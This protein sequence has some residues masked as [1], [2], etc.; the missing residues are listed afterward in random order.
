MA[1]F[2]F[3]LDSVLRWR[4]AERDQRR[5]AVADAMRLEQLA[6]DRIIACD[7]E[8]Q[9]L[10]ENDG[11][12]GAID[13][14]RRVASEQYAAALRRDRQRL[15]VE[16]SER[17]AEVDSSRAALVEADREVRMLERLRERKLEAFE[18]AERRRQQSGMEELALRKHLAEQDA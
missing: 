12:T 6:Q 18:A 14:A 3:A 1:K 5:Q 2:T 10:R 4:T 17:T 8:L 13:I 16:R 9:K 7:G 11:S 15:V